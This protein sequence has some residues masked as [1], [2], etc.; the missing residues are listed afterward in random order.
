MTSAALNWAP[1]RWQRGLKAR[2]PLE[3]QNSVLW[4]Q[5]TGL[6]NCISSGPPGSD[7]CLCW[8]RW[9]LAAGPTTGRNCRCCPA[10]RL[11]QADFLHGQMFSRCLAFASPDHGFTSRPLITRTN[12]RA[13][14][15]RERR[16]DDSRLYSR[17]AA[18]SAEHGGFMSAGRQ[19]SAAASKPGPPRWMVWWLTDVIC[20]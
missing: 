3:M 11:N 10:L 18:P 16:S 4:S 2:I 12:R 8:G 14:P 9:L 7:E 1:A 19:K 5:P 15:A 17:A 6:R 20:H 13:A